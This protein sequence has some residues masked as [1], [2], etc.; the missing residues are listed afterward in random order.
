MISRDFLLGVT[1]SESEIRLVHVK[2]A[3]R[4]HDKRFTPWHANWRMGRTRDSVRCDAWGC[5]PGEV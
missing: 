1:G 5:G 4:W 2:Q 3:S